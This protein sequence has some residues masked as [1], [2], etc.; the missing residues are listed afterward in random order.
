M[1]RIARSCTTYAMVAALAIIVMAIPSVYAAL[2][3]NTYFYL[4]GTPSRGTSAAACGGT[5]GTLSTSTNA[6]SPITLSGSS[7]TNGFYCFATTSTYSLSTSTDSGQ[8]TFQF[9]WNGAGWAASTVT[10]A[11]FSSATRTTK[12]TQ[13]GSGTLSVPSG[14]SGSQTIAINVANGG[15]GC[16][17]TCYLQFGIKSS[18]ATTTSVTMA[19]S[20]STNSWLIGPP[21]YQ[22]SYSINGG[23]SGYTAPTLTYT[24]AGVTGQ[25]L[26]LTTSSQSVY[27]DLGTIY[28]VTNPL[29]GSTGIERWSTATASGTS[30]IGGGTVVFTYYHQYLQTL[31]YSISGGGSPTGPTY[32]ANQYGSSSPQSLTATG[33]GYWYDSGSTWSVSPN[34]LSGSTGS[35]RWQSSQA[36][37]G[38]ISSSSTVVFTFYHQYLQT[39]SYA[40]SGGGTP[41]AP[42]YSANQYGA[43]TPQTLT[44][45]ATSY[46]Y[47]AGS[48]WSVTNPLGGSTGSEQW[49]TV[50][51]SGS[52]GGAAT[53]AFAYYHQYL[54]TLSYSIVGG[55]SGYTAPTFSCNRYGSSAPQVLTTTA[56]GYWFDNG[57]PWTVTNPLGG[58][59]GSEQWVTV[60]STSGT[61]SSTQT[62]AFSYQNQYYLTMQAGTGGTVTPS[63][64]WQNSG[65]VVAITGIPNSGYGFS[66]WTCSGA[67]CYAGTANPSSVTA[68]AAITETGNFNIITIRIDNR[69]LTTTFGSANMTAPQ[70]VNPTV[71]YW[72][73]AGGYDSQHTTDVQSVTLDL[74]R[75]GHSPGTFA[76]S[77]VY[78]FRWVANG[79]SGAPSCS[80]APGC[81]QE[82][83]STGWVSTGFNYLISTDCSVTT[84]SASTQTANWQFAIKLDQLAVYT[85]NGAGLWN[86]KATI[87]SKSGGVSSGTRAGT[88]DVNL[89]I[90]VIV[91]GNMD[92]GTVAAGSTN[93]TASGMPVYTTY[94]ANAIVSIT[95][96]GNGNPVDQ[97]GDT[98]TLSSIYVAKTSN[99]ANN[100][101]VLL[102]TS[103]VVL[104]SSLPVAANSNLAMYWFISTPN[105]FTPGT[106]TFTYS[107]TIQLQSMQP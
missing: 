31:S 55:G 34:P 41:T 96:Y 9:V 98:F 24:K 77:F 12:G 36:L 58:S 59:G 100:D 48:S 63:S 37:T 92:W 81:W 62:I 57:A 71:E 18:A 101:G 32:T 50:T 1:V 14:S 105:P 27:I 15:A 67:G 16:T 80:T 94:T 13:I 17:S 8:Y 30:A 51:S 86:F 42:T 33:T 39:L 3:A 52:I 99:P 2:P 29:G 66:S 61:I 44:T 89:L 79:W 60:Q 5:W 40:V 20:S 85:T 54:Q 76:A 19:V 91:P 69:T 74:Y 11:I 93:A 70:A 83:Q 43:S 73:G 90:S 47:D 72:Y 65:S 35:E 87:T 78:S 45:T 95:V 25:T 104:Y 56:T 26:V 21:V 49:A 68:S 84:I 97:Y 38:T 103:P 28:S 64:G 107:E 4:S 23:G 53:I 6:Q 106:Y 7:T 102:S 88:Y 82:L 22:I 46:W 10:V 75:T